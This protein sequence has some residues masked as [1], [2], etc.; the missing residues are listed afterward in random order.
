MP[1]GA[2]GLFY[3]SDLKIFT[4]P[5]V[6]AS[7]V[8]DR[9]VSDVWKHTWHLPFS[10]HPVGAI[11]NRASWKHATSNWP[12][13]RDSSNRGGEVTPARAFAPVRIYHHDWD[14]M[15]EDMNMNPEECEEFF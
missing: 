3:C 2:I 7:K 15:L 4:T 5:F 13:L 1:C 11:D 14:T 6:V 9:I 10:I 12:F 8:V